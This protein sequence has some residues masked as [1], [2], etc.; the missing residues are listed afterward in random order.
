MVLRKYQARLGQPINER[1]YTYMQGSKL[2]SYSLICPWC[3]KGKT[4]AN[5]FADAEIS[6]VCSKC[7]KPYRGSLRNF[8]TFKATAIPKGAGA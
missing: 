5:G 8:K 3:G 2:F 6:C 1:G 4:L 7:K